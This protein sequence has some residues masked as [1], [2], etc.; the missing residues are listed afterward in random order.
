MFPS[1]SYFRQCLEYKFPLVQPADS[2]DNNTGGALCGNKCIFHR[3]MSESGV[4][5][6]RCNND[7]IIVLLHKYE[8]FSDGF[9]PLLYRYGCRGGTVEGGRRTLE[10]QVFD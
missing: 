2:V 5:I 9:N 10:I 6:R 4:I 3:N 7:Y 8:C 1:R